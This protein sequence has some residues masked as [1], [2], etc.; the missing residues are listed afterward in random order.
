MLRKLACLAL[1]TIVLASGADAALPKIQMLDRLAVSQG[2]ATV[3]LTKGT[4]VA[5]VALAPLPAVIDTGD[6]ATG[7]TAT[8]YKAYLTSSTDASIEIPLGSIYPNTKGKA[9]IK[10]GLKGDV[11]LLGLDRVVVVAYSADGLSSFDLLTGTI[12][13]L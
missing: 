2:N 12:P 7:F 1:L 6:V 4:V 5:T 3:S 10:A 8:I 9:A 11:S 13:T